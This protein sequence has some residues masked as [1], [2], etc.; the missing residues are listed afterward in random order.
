MRSLVYIAGTAS[1]MLLKKYIWT[2]N[3]IWFPCGTVFILTALMI[4]LV[5]PYQKACMS[6]VDTLL[7]SNLALAYFAAS[8]K[9]FLI[10]V[11]RIIFA[12]PMLALIL[13]IL[14][15]KVREST[16]LKYFLSQR[17]CRCK[18][19]WDIE[20]SSS[21]VTAE[22]SEEQLLFIQSATASTEANNYGMY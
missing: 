13:T 15:R 4:A 17:C 8:S 19:K 21:D 18:L 12:L 6:Y 14:L 10:L 5:K 3:D 9:T 22:T 16:I 20:Q 1:N 11:I 2:Y 7:P